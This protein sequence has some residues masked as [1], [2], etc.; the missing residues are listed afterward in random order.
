MIKN[1]H[2][3]YKI[4]KLPYKSRKRIEEMQL[5]KLQRLL[6]HANRNVELYE[7][8]FRDVDLNQ[9]NSLL[10]LKEIPFALPSDFR[11]VEVQRTVAKNVPQ[12]ELITQKTSGTTSEPMSFL[13]SREEDKMRQLKSLRF[14]WQHGWKPWWKGVHIWRDVSQKKYSIFQRLINNRRSF[15]SINLPI[16]KQ[17]EKIMEIRP[18][19][20]FGLT[21]SLEVVADWMLANNKSYKT[22]LVYSGGEFKSLN[23]HR[24]FEKA[25]G[26]P[27]IERYGSVE[28]GLIAFTCPHCGNYYVDEDGFILEVLDDQNNP[29]KNGQVGRA[30]I[31]ALDQYTMPVIRYDIG[32]RIALLDEP[33]E[34]KIHY[35]HF[36]RVDGRETDKIVLE[37]GRVIVFQHVIQ[38]INCTDG[39]NKI[40][41]RQNRG[42][43]ILIKYIKD[44]KVDQ[45]EFEAELSKKLRLDK[46]R[47]TFEDCR[48][49]ANEPNGKYRLVKSE[50]GAPYE[51]T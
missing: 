28:C 31:T 6:L 43:D 35:K 8:K 44:K 29:V 18:D 14:Q 30:V 36:K 2:N 13:N 16:E 42:G 37:N 3:F 4:L 15:V 50:L 47:V 21:S 26:H 22:R 38:L 12:N 34:C 46:A 19:M 49:I 9:V 7:D 45:Y 48:Y 32:D 11:G 20:I 23:V 1:L 51:Y 40:Q 5:W 25:F 17:V 41:L 33:V 39:L 24:K 27:G 10:D